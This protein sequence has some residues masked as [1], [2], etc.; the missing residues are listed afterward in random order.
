M[1]AAPTFF[2][3]ACAAIIAGCSDN[4]APQGQNPQASVEHMCQSSGIVVSDAWVRTS[5]A[6]QPTSAAYLKITNCGDADDALVAVAFDGAAAAELHATAMSANAI[7]TMTPTKT[8][9]LP[10]GQTVELAPG[11]AHI[12]LIGLTGALDEDDDPAMTLKFENADALTLNF[13][14]RPMT[15]APGPGGH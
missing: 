4:A 14:V 11:G 10:A 15:G 9:A 6:G 13:E 12:M 3:T 1:H 8:L 5:R 2:L 7:A